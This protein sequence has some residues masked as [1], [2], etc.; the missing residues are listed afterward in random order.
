MSDPLVERFRA[1]EAAW[2]AEHDAIP[3]APAPSLA[4]YRVSVGDAGDVQGDGH[5]EPQPGRYERCPR[6]V[7]WWMLNTA[8]GEKVPA[9]CKSNGCP[10]CIVINARLVAGAI[11]LARPERAVR[12]SLVGDDFQTTRNRVKR[13]TY[14]LRKRGYEW[15]MAW[16]REPNPKGTGHHTHGWQTGDYVPQA[17]L[18]EV[19]QT[20][21]LGLPWIERMKQETGAVGYGLK[22]VHY[23]LKM[24]DAD[25]QAQT[26]LQA[27]GGR[28]VHATRGF[29]RD[30]HGNPCGQRAAMKAYARLR[31]NGEGEDSWVL[32]HDGE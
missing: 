32:V 27:N 24:T 30:E 10:Y 21:G 15:Q 20:E 19:C 3:T 6:K 23:G 7:G 4:L 18:Q 9:R 28:L 5:D 17:L 13:V 22:G 31:S 14:Q 11:A 12:F 1:D 26:Y 29:W 8:T 25:A 16:H 2:D